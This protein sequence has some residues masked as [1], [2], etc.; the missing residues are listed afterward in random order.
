MML[1]I[2]NQRIR[3]YISLMKIGVFVLV[4][5]V[6]TNAMSK[7]TEALTNEISPGPSNG[8]L[9]K[10]ATA[11]VKNNNHLAG[12]HD[13]A[14]GTKCADCHGKS[15]IP[16]D[17]AVTINEN[18]VSCHGD[19]TELAAITAKKAKNPDIN[20]HNSHLGPEISCT[21]CHQGHKESVTYCTNCHTNFDLPIPGGSQ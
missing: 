7:Q 20:V 2:K 11:D 21:T 5:G 19:Y 8:E 17:N 9:I 18:C 1:L 10:K 6:Q 12:I 14:L 15:M 13:K 3:K 4:M 16:E